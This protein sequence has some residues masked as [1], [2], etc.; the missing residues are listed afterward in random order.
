VGIDEMGDGIVQKNTKR[1]KDLG[2]KHKKE[3]W[4]FFC[5]RFFCLGARVPI[6]LPIRIRRL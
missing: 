1:Q 6:T 5:P 4:L 3:Q 2:Q